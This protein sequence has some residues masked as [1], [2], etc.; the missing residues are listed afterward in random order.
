MYKL[1][2]SIPFLVSITACFNSGDPQPGAAHQAAIACQVDVAV[3]TARL[4]DEIALPEVPGDGKPTLGLVCCEAPEGSDGCAPMDHSVDE[5]TKLPTPVEATTLKLHSTVPYK[6]AGST[7]A[8]F[9]NC[10]P[11]PETDCDA[12]ETPYVFQ[13]YPQTRWMVALVP[14]KSG[15]GGMSA[16]LYRIPVGS[17]SVKIPSGRE[18]F[19]LLPATDGF[20]DP[21]RGVETPDGELFVDKQNDCIPRADGCGF[22]CSTC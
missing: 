18:I 21:E 1:A 3:A 14:S 8:F 17:T 6:G 20:A 11:P 9:A 12:T 13:P 7:T 2:F 5:C 19:P 22:T 16:E 15:K 4:S 10:E